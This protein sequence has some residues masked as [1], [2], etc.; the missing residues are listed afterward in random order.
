MGYVFPLNISLIT[1]LPSI[2]GVTMKFSCEFLFCY[3]PGGCNGV[4]IPSEY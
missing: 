2:G 1:G 3:N 4:R